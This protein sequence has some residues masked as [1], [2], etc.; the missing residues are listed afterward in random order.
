M[1][2]RSKRPQKVRFQC[3]NGHEYPKMV[4][5]V[6]MTK[7]LYLEQTKRCAYYSYVLFYVFCKRFCMCCL[8][9]CL[10][11]FQKI[12]FYEIKRTQSKNTKIQNCN[13]DSPY[14][15]NECQTML[16]HSNFFHTGILYGPIQAF[17][18]KIYPMYCNNDKCQ[19]DCQEFDGTLLHIYNINN[20]KLFTHSVLNGFSSFVN[21]SSV[22]MHAYIRNVNRTFVF[23]L[24]KKYILTT[25]KRTTFWNKKQHRKN[26]TTN[27]TKS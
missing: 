8:F 20:S 2:K 24:F 21:T 5:A 1:S 13:R 27:I 10:F 19:F 26:L 3:H 11:L 16:Q 18:V 25:Q 4:N 23:F 7:V 15:C 14:P 17:D 22:A 12:C 9:C 6:C